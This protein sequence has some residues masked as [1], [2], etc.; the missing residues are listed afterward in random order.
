[1][2]PLQ[3]DFPLWFRLR[4]LTYTVVLGAFFAVLWC[5]TGLE[6]TVV[7]FTIFGTILVMSPLAETL[8]DT[9]STGPLQMSDTLISRQCLGGSYEMK[10]DEVER[11]ERPVIGLRWLVFHG[12]NKHLGVAGPD[13]WSGDDRAEMLALLEEQIEKRGIPVERTTK[14]GWQ[15]AKNTKIS[16]KRQTVKSGL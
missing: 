11:I 5:L 7:A 1:M 15:T 10:W 3:V 16:A 12:K 13:L 14:G 8:T 4:P 2:K 9:F 6:E